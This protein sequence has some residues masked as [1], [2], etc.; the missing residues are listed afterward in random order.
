MARSRAA[1]RTSLR[2][3]AREQGWALSAVQRAIRTG[4]LTKASVRKRRGRWQLVDAEKAKAEWAAHTRP[5]V[6][7]RKVPAAGAEAPSE[8]AQA[9]L[10]ERLA[11]AESFE[12][13]TAKKR[14]QL[15]SVM[16]MD[17]RWA[18]AGLR[19]RTGLLGLPTRA[20]QRIPHLTAKDTITLD[21]L[22]RE[23]LEELAGPVEREGAHGAAS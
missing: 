15:V 23:L 2:A 4:R 21:A 1:G 8:L 3:F 19:L 10:R 9:T 22:V 14:G 13:E 12:L 20:R 5:R 7:S 11:R 17:R 18:A 6:D 16:E